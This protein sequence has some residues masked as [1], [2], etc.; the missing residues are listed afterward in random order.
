[1]DATSLSIFSGLFGVVFWGVVVGLLARRKN[2]SPL[3]WGIAGGLV[4][5]IA[6]II[7]AMMPY[8]CPRCGQPL[9]NTQGREEHCPNC[10]SFKAL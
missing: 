9:S 6:L 5:F 2:R 4:W 10:G 7:L 3:G 8:K 1:M